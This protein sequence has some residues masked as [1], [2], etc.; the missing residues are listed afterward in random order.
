MK[1][2]WVNMRKYKMSKMP[3]RFYLPRFSKA[4]NGKIWQFRILRDYGFDLDFRKDFQITDLLTD[5]EK[6][7]F[8]INIWLFG[9]RN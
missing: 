7:R 9:K 1:I 2:V 4:W 3:F 6:K 5:N 8:F